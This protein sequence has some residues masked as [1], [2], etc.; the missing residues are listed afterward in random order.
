MVKG[1]QNL[2]KIWCTWKK[3][4]RN[5]VRL[6]QSVNFTR[7]SHLM[8]SNTTSALT[9]AQITVLTTLTEKVKRNVSAQMSV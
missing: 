1:A 4:H 2:A 3:G 5:I 6:C 8:V 9:T 7:K